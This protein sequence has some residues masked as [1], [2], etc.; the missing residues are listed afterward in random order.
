MS[1]LR[2]MNSRERSDD[3]TGRNLSNMGE[4]ATAEF[5]STTVER[6]QQRQEA[7][8][9]R[10]RE[11]DFLLLS[12][13]VNVFRGREQPEPSVRL[14]QAKI[15]LADEDYYRYKDFEQKMLEIEDYVKF[16]DK[17]RH[18][19]DEGLIREIKNMIYVH[20][21]WI[22]KATEPTRVTLNP[23]RVDISNR[24]LN[25]VK[26]PERRAAISNVK[27]PK[28]SRELA[29]NAPAIH[30]T[31][32]QVDPDPFM[33]TKQLAQI[34]REQQERWARVR[35]GTGTPP[36]YNGPYIPTMHVDD[37]GNQVSSTPT[38]EAK[39]YLEE[40]MD[41]QLSEL[42][43]DLFEPLPPGESLSIKDAARELQKAVIEEHHLNH[44][45]RNPNFAELWAFAADRKTPATQFFSLDR[46]PPQL[47][48]EERQKQ[49]GESGP[50]RPP[51]V[52]KAVPGP[53]PVRDPRER[54]VRGSAVFPFG[55]TPQQAAIK[56]AQISNALKDGKPYYI[57]SQSCIN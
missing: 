49:I 33:Y 54:Y 13:P 55:E 14:G 42:L 53:E 18:H 36:N 25:L 35:K 22:K 37:G 46:W 32:D 57:S 48:T 51:P 7:D 21:E 23:P 1:A 27:A 38:P 47:Q 26:D 8:L 12:K 5:M 15:F 2:S 31:L 43:A 52:E 3:R 41:S 24:L 40:T 45:T 29:R 28:I 9:Q 56:G 34:R 30:G 19:G 4:G 44:D 6:A 17:N 39:V 10:Q 50:V 16:L 11:A 20:K